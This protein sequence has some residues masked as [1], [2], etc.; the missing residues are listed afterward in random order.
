MTTH[1]AALCILLAPMALAGL[2][3]CQTSSPT[4]QQVDSTPKPELALHGGTDPK[5]DLAF[6]Q[7]ACGGCHAVEPP[8][9]SP[10]PASPTFAD[11]ANS[12]GLTDDTLAIWLIDAHNYP[13]EMDFDLNQEQVETIA[14]HMV[15]LRNPDYE[16]P[17]Y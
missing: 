16:K 15:R 8:G 5:T 7:G 6:A 13:E 11:I 10:N 1:R 17:A 14:R 4:A 12:P 2:A 3:S 9:L